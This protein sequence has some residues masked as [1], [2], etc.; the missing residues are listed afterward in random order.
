MY[1][2]DFLKDMD[3][4][5]VRLLDDTS[6]SQ[7]GTKHITFNFILHSNIIPILGSHYTSPKQKM[8][9]ASVHTHKYIQV[10]HIR[11]GLAPPEVLK[12]FLI[13]E[14]KWQP[15][16]TGVLKK[17][18]SN[19]KE[20]RPKRRKPAHPQGTL[21]KAMDFNNILTMHLKE[22][23]PEHRTGGHKCILSVVEEFFK[24]TKAVLIRHK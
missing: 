14:E 1:N 3:W 17:V 5:V 6:I 22:L 13:E 8:R 18:V 11:Q 10:I 19:C 12:A 2:A 21:P 16:Y 9:T 20:C 15:T 24:Y 4:H 23:T 7:T